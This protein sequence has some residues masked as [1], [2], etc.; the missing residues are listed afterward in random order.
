MASEHLV[1]QNLRS[2][3][4]AR[5]LTWVCQ[6]G[7]AQCVAIRHFKYMIFQRT[8]QSLG[9]LIFGQPACKSGHDSAACAWKLC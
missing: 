5:I 1:L 8:Q 2:D 3:L 6:Q 9:S 7:A 4:P